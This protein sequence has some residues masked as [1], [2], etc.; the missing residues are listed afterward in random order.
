MNNGLN[1]I[2]QTQQECLN[3]LEKLE[4]EAQAQA[5]A[6]GICRAGIP[7]EKQAKQMLGA[8]ADKQM[9]PSAIAAQELPI[10]SAVKGLDSL[11]RFAHELANEVELRVRP[12]CSSAPPTNDA[13]QKRSAS[14]I[15]LIEALDA[16]AERVQLI[17]D[18][19]RGILARLAI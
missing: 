5:R 16:A 12:V 4:K 19:Q 3:T 15:P 6:A 13:G 18:I 1:Y 11:L 14:D 9:T 10:V 8:R 7:F 17:I 2:M